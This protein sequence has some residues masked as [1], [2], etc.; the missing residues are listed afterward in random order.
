MGVFMREIKKTDKV[1]AI[2]HAVEDFV[3]E[4]AQLSDMRISDIAKRAGIG[5]G[6]TYEYFTSKEELVV[7]AMVYLVGTM[8]KRIINNM[9]KLETFQD[10]FMLLLAEMEEK[11]KQRAC[12]LKYFHMLGDLNLCEQMQEVLLGDKDA[13]ESN[14]MRIIRYLI[15][16]GKKE[17]ILGEQYSDSYMET[18]VFSKVIAFVVYIDN[19]FGN[20]QCSN[21]IM[22]QEIYKGLCRELGA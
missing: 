1:I 10:K 21:E 9:E 18:A 8:T 15:L 20:R 2:Y 4:G 6:T 22:K 5:K 3:A 13:N 11:V 14:P 17:G 16:Q 7:K 12:I 19:V